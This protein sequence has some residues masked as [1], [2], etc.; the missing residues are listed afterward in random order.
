MNGLTNNLTKGA[1]MMAINEEKMNE[2]QGRFQAIP[3]RARDA[4]QS[5][6]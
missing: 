3:S 1:T 2:L 6:L 5:C 4:F